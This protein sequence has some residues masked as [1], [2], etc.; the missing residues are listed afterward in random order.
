MKKYVLAIVIASG[1]LLGLSAQAA[2][3]STAASAVPSQ[4]TS[5]TEKVWHYRHWHH[6]WGYR[7]WYG[8][9]RYWSH[10]RHG[11]WGW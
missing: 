6:G 11:S 5:G 1:A 2:P 10:R 3:V 7:R 8:H 4:V 9:G